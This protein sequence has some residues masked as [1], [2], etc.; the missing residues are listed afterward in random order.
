MAL[1]RVFGIVLLALTAFA[2]AAMFISW[3][4]GTTMV[5]GFNTPWT[6]KFVEELPVWS[7]PFIGGVIGVFVMLFSSWALW[8][9]QKQQADKYQRQV[10]KAKR[11]ITERNQAIED[12]EQRISELEAEL[13][14]AKGSEV[15]AAG[16][17]TATGG[18]PADARPEPVGEDDDE[19]AI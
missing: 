15:E 18:K 6:S 4:A 2:Y 13:A 1:L 5:V 16:E 17:T 7:L 3:N 10:E 11:I 9:G 14:A 19:E 12:Q 8:S